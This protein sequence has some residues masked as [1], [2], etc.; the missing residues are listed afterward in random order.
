MRPLRGQDA[1]Q[2]QVD[3]DACKRRITDDRSW[4]EDPRLSS[5]L[6]DPATGLAFSVATE[7]V[8]ADRYT[9][10]LAER[11]YAT[12]LRPMTGP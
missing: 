1:D 9:R 6:V 4:A 11:G 7:K 3:I 5:P 2:V 10:C 12:E 8:R